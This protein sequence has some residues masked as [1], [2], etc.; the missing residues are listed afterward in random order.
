MTCAPR[1]TRWHRPRRPRP[2]NLTLNPNSGSPEIW[3][4]WTT[5]TDDTDPPNL[6]LYDV[7]QNGVFAEHGSIGA[8]ET[9]VSCDFT[10][11][12]D[13]VARAVDT[14]GNVS[15]PSNAITFDC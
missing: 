5:S 6:I 15:G 8:G 9:I 14:S 10:G 7:Y 3:L 4:D 13:V 2:T 12:T 11:P 1:C